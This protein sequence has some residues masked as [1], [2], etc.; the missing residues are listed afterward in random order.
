M[1]P[2]VSKMS[3][4]NEI[5]LLYNED[6]SVQGRAKLKCTVEAITKSHNETKTIE[7]V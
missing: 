1:L 2:E 3:Q 5:K 7:T 6:T 4:E